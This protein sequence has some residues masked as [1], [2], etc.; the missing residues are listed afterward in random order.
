VIFIDRAA[1]RTGKL[2]R[3]PVAWFTA[4]QTA[5]T[6]A[7]AEKENH[8]AVATVYG[9]DRVRAALEELFHHKCAY[10]E[11]QITA[12]SSWDVE[13]FRPKGRVAER[14]DHPGYYWLAYTWDNLY[15]SCALCNQNR[16]D[17]PLYDDP[18]EL[19]AAGKL[20]QFPV[21]DEQY[22]TMSHTADPTL[23]QP[24]LLDPC[25]DRPEQFL[26]VDLRGKVLARDGNLRG[27]TSIRVFHLNRRRL[28]RVRRGL[29]EKAIRIARNIRTLEQQGNAAGV[30]AFRETMTDF[31]D[32]NVPYSTVFRAVNDDPDAFGL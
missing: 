19:P 11:S 12:A 6:T 1:P 16:K 23:E 15:P 26:T 2:I 24:L 30:K 28:Q 10:C 3:P 17:K 29:A 13:H 18:K 32:D 4:A 8:V 5:T 20:D 31:M 14:R 21:E 25:R 9:H 22:R 27:E 7:L